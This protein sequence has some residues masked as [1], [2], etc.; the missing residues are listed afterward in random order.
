MSSVPDLQLLVPGLCGPLPEI[1]PLLTD[2]DC[3]RV[4]SLLAKARATTLETDRLAPLL[5]NL[6]K[7]DIN[8]EFPSAALSLRGYLER[9]ETPLTMPA[10][11]LEG[12]LNGGGYFL[13]AD[14][15][16]LRA[17]MD[18]AILLGTQELNIGP[19]EATALT[20]QLQTHFAEDDVRLF[21]MDAAHWFVHVKQP[22]ALQTVE[23]SD[24]VGRNVNFI[25]PQ[26]EDASYWKSFLN[27]AQMLLSMQAENQQR[28]QQGQL[29]VNSVWLHGGG[30][31]PSVQEMT[32][33][34]VYSD[35][36]LLQGLANISDLTC[37][38]VDASVDVF[39]SQIAEQAMPLLYIN[40]LSPWLN[41][42]DAEM[43][44]RQL[45]VFATQWLQPLLA[46]VRQGKLTL[47]LYPA[48]N[49]CYHFGRF[50]SYRFWRKAKIENYVSHY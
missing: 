29:T 50:D 46:Q 1:Q 41:Y 15:V 45:Q 21:A 30:C 9:G 49:Q 34:A 17:D 27:E 32:V 26:G 36:A 44:R 8:D 42:T 37:S 3:Q 23:L 12:L 13:H 31:L 35:D 10:A 16:H 33:S 38:P 18:H 20:Q 14:P 11:E 6:F 22:Q 40:S 47:T 5:A 25:L 48:N 4:F 39:M 7:L 2:T 28:E 43:W 19:I 24:A